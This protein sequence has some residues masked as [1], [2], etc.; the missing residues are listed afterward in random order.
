[1]VVLL[2]ET[3]V[4]VNIMKSEDK[5]EFN[6]ME[7]LLQPFRKRSK[8]VRVA[9][10]IL[11]LLAIV[12]P[13]FSV[14]NIYEGIASL[15]IIIILLLFSC[16]RGKWEIFLSCAWSLLIVINLV[17]T[18]FI[19]AP[20]FGLLNE[21]RIQQMKEEKFYNGFAE[22]L[23][24]LSVGDYED[25]IS[26]FEDIRNIVPD[27]Y[28]LEYYL[29]YGETTIY[30][31]NNAL[32]MDLLN[33]AEREI[34][35]YSDKER[36]VLFRLIPIC[37]MINY[38]NEQ[39][40]DLL[41][42]TAKQY[43]STNEQIFALFELTSL[44]VQ[45][46]MTVCESRI[47]EIIV[48]YAEMDA[49]ESDLERMKLELLAISACSLAEDYPEY[50]VVLFAELY[51]ENKSFFYENFLYWYPTE[52]NFSNMRWFSMDCLKIMKE[53]Y[54]EGWEK[55]QNDDSGE[56]Q[57]YSKSIEE[58]GY[59]LGDSSIV[60]QILEERDIDWKIDEKYEQWEIYNI[61]PIEDDSYLMI[62]LDTIEMGKES[63]H[64]PKM[65]GE[66]QF[67]VLEMKDEQCSLTPVM[68]DGA[69]FSKIVTM[70]KLFL[71]EA[72]EENGKFLIT[73]IEGTGE[74]LYLEV[75]DLENKTIRNIEG[76]TV[77]YHSAGFE[78]DEKNSYTVDFEIE[79]GMDANMASKVGGKLK[80]I[81]D[82]NKYTILEE[83]SYLDPGVE[84]Y[85]EER[86]AA[87]IFP[88]QNLDTLNG[89]EIKNDVLL[90][91]IRQNSLPYYKYTLLQQSYEY[92]LYI[93]DCKFSGLTV[94]YDAGTDQETTFFFFVQRDEENVKLLGIYQVMD[95]GIESVY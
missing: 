22:A 29:W 5:R 50:A 3:Y 66:A 31:K 95:D 19:G 79:N 7:F 39:D 42:K 21:G 57:K 43:Q 40:Y 17:A 92:F 25:A 32:S 51:E 69:E 61:V 88:L 11:V 84:F 28:L 15:F 62:F 90:D 34:T 75:L 91:K 47:R 8:A 70:N 2:N 13:F 16:I 52:Y 37:K 85:V 89:K 80:A 76:Q 53:I 67:Y 94:V 27:E 18:P 24:E 41:Q 71:V 82:F 36:D 12:F 58:L 78:F 23:F 86:N 35:E 83:V 63:N 68:I 81:I 87:L 54:S 65:V 93:A 59:Y 72:T 9:I 55:F 1:M 4:E 45:E 56:L 74:Y 6:I 14:S 77:T 33:E 38:L 10:G 26:S 73:T 46:D 48:Q 44:C 64:L 49:G 30:A 60:M 20:F